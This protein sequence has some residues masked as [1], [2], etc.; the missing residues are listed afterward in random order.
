MSK[1]KHKM[2]FVVAIIVVVILFISAFTLKQYS[3]REIARTS[4]YPSST[5]TIFLYGEYHGK[6]EY[7]S[8]EFTIWKSY[9]NQK[10]MRDLFIEAEYYTAQMLNVWLHETDDDILNVIYNNSEG[11][12]SHTKAQLDF[13][14]KIKEECPETI[15]HGTDIGHIKET[16]EWYLKY[17]ENHG[18]SDSIEYKLTEENIAQ[19][20]KYYA[21]A[22]EDNAYRE[23]CMVQ[24]FIREYDKIKGT[25]V[26]GIYGDAHS[27]PSDSSIENNTHRMAYQLKQH[28]GD[29][30]QY[31]SIVSLTK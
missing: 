16:G 10:G 7:I 27:D 17:L 28:Y 12:L 8:K 21:N 29:I 3:S 19:G 25:A 23:N 4:Y 1:K 18:M 24:N 15:F 31:E 5:A 26:M 14:K 20:D 9:Y 6:E 13:Y 30:I 11:T 22:E 2:L